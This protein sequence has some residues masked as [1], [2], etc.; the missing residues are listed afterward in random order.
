[1]KRAAATVLAGLICLPVPLAADTPLGTCLAPLEPYAFEPPR[2]DP[3]LY[4]MVRQDYQ[5]YLTDLEA[6]LRCLEDE[7]RRAVEN[8]N[9]VLRRY[10]EYFGDDATIRYGPTN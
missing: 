10:I 9:A 3:G 2:D 1:M 7:R 4:E 5:T 8:G 6:Y